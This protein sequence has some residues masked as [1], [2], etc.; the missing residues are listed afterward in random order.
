MTQ[1][2]RKIGLVC[3]HPFS[4]RGGVQRHVTALYHEFKALGLEVKIIAPGRGRPDGVPLEDVINIGVS[5]SINVN[6]SRGH[7]NASLN[8]KRVPQ[9]LKEEEFAILHFHNMDVGLLSGQFLRAS[10]AVNIG[11]FHGSLDGSRAVRWFP[12]LPKLI[13]RVLYR[14]P[15]DGGIAVS[16]A[17]MDTLQKFPGL[18]TIIPNGVDHARFRPDVP[19]LER[20]EF[21]DGKTNILFVGRFEKRKG[22]SYLLRAYRE[23]AKRRSDIRLILVG[24]SGF[25]SCLKAKWFVRWH[26]LGERVWFEGKV[27]DDLLPS[28]YAT[29]HVFCAP[30]VSGE[31]FGMVLLEAMRCG[32]PAVGFG[33]P[34]YR[35]VMSQDWN[36]ND[37][38]TLESLLVNPKD[39]RALAAKIEEL[40]DNPALYEKAR[41]RGLALCNRFAWGPIAENILA[42]YKNVMAEKL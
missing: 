29:A 11:T 5:V 36:K 26:G 10:G 17:A 14:R 34:G 28:Y 32:T 3:A 42:F 41:A 39:W 16:E 18:K 13:Y 6:G 15:M 33:N 23:L 21:R 22:V 2:I 25:V 20:E 8:L 7:A 40:L 19:L 12:F 30:S 24:E 31:S 4:K 9:I 1:E 38:F 27:S 35:G 37:G